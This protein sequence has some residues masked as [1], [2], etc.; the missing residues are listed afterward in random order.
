VPDEENEKKRCNRNKKKKRAL[1]QD[2]SKEVI[3]ARGG[4][5]SGR[6]TWMVVALAEVV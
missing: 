2:L 5:G 6:L 1:W 4:E 3:A